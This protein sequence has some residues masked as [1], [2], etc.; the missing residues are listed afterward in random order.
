MSATRWE[1]RVEIIKAIKFQ[2]AKIRE[3]LLQVVDTDNDSKIQ[4]EANFL[5]KN[6]LGDWVFY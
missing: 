4:R 3:A 1:S 5:A 6:E 2:V